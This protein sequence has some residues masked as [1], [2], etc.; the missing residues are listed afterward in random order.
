V[1]SCSLL[2]LFCL[3]KSAPT[4]V[5]PPSNNEYLAYCVNQEQKSEKL[6]RQLCS[7]LRRIQQRHKCTDSVC[8]DVVLTLSKYLS[9]TP[10]NFR[11]YDK[12]MQKE[13][14]V[15]FLALNGC[16]GCNEFVFLPEDPRQVCPKCGDPRYDSLGK[17]LEVMFCLLAINLFYFCSIYFIFDLSIL[18]LIYLFYFC[19][20]YVLFD[21]ACCIFL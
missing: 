8:A 2:R 13:A 3:I 14:G 21:S 4:S 18:F 11:K 1:L 19:S 6:V 17:P 10:A 16:P 15:R 12:I 7:D 20:Q 9:V 5:V